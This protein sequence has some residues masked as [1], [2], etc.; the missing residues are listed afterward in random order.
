M[1]DTKGPLGQ[2]TA[3][4]Q[5]YDASVLFAIERSLGRKQT[6]HYSQN[7]IM[8]GADIWQ[9]FE[10]SWLGPKGKPQV[11]CL[12]LY[13]P[14]NSLY[15]VES[16]S[17]K[18]YLNSFNQTKFESADRVKQRI[19]KDLSAVVGAE[20]KVEVLLP[21]QWPQLLPEPVMGKCLDDLDIEVLDYS[22]KESLL[23]SAVTSSGDLV[24][25]QLYSHL[26]RSN[27]PVT[28][29]PDWGSII[30]N[31]SGL[32]ID[33]ASLLKYLVSFRQHQGF[34]EQ[35]I[36][37]IYCD[38]SHYCK[39]TKLMICGYYL[40]RGGLDISPIRSSDEYI[41]QGQRCIRQ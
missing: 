31:Y 8:H 39:P 15:I 5:Q 10:L 23:A 12:R 21:A 11:A 28:E 37:Q 9:G 4:P 36:E 38:I 22:P 34:H 6:K 27:C 7:T 18:L 17:L 40:R 19:H 33:E 35:C 16:K 3:Y 41:F 13:V 2:T 1:Q 25:R 14:S 24:S 20:V 32:E 30:I 26:L 29:Q